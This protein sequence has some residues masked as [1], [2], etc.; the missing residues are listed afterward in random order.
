MGP[1]ERRQRENPVANLIV[2]VMWITAEDR[3][4]GD[5]RPY[6]PPLY[7][8][9]RLKRQPRVMFSIRP[10][11]AEYRQA[12]RGT[13]MQRLCGWRMKWREDGAVVVLSLRGL[14]GSA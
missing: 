8:T 6:L 13:V 11:I 10:V 12:W 4:R 5:G 7:A 2:R 1:E 3:H 14:G 9:R